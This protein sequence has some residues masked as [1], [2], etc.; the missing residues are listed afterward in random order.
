MPG[1]SSATTPSARRRHRSRQQV[2]VADEVGDEPRR[3]QAVDP[4]GLVELLDAAAVHHRDPVR[5]RERLGLVVRHVDERD[6]DLLLQVDE[7]DLHLLAQ[8]RVEGGERLVEQQERRVGHERARDRDALPLAARQLVRHALAEAGEPH[9]L[10]RLGDLRRHVRGRH[11]RHLQRERD[12]A[13]DGHVREQRVALEHRAHRTALR[14]AADEVLAVEHDAA[15]VGQVEARDHP[16]ERRLAAAGGPQQREELA[17][18]DGEADVVDGG[19]VAE[20]A[21]DPLDFEQR[22]GRDPPS[23]TVGRR[24]RGL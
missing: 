2:A 7:L 18:L 24:V 16:Q 1:T 19:E 8:L 22:H 13:F 15:G 9:V 11:L 17:R 20:P 4:R 10:E 3:G 23:A 14:R 12:V 21:R 5:E 6:A